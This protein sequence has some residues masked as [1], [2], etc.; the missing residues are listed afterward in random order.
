MAQK[1][2]SWP[3]IFLLALL[4]ISCAPAIPGQAEPEITATEQIQGQGPL[5]FDALPARSPLTSAELEETAAWIF[6]RIFQTSASPSA[7]FPVENS[8]PAL[9]FLS[10]SDGASKADVLRA[11]GETLQIRRPGAHQPVQCPPPQRFWN[12]VGQA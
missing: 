6:G 2:K 1:L 3:S 11:S 4:L 12:P 7:P 10:L 5:W 9:L 8:Q